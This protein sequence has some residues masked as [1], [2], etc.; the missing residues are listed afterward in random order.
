MYLPTI[1]AVSSNPALRAQAILFLVLYN[2]MFI[3]PLIVVFILAF[4]GTTSK[5]LMNFMEK[6]SAAVKLGM[7]LLFLAL[8]SWLLYSLFLK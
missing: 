6:H 5:D 4:Y 7:A 1:I 8:S 3:V 2:V